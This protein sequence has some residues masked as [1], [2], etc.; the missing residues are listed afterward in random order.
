MADFRKLFLVLAVIA[1][2]AMS[3]SAQSNFSC[4]VSPATPATLRSGGLT[5]ELGDAKYTCSG[6]PT[7]GT[8]NG[9]F[10]A[11]IPGATVTNRLVSGTN[12][13]VGF[14]LVGVALSVETRDPT[15]AR[16]WVI[17]RWFTGL[18]QPS[19]PDSPA[20][21]NVIAFPNVTIPDR[22]YE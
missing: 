2:T 3:A 10:T 13:G 6:G 1:I 22:N 5:E 12:S 18:L 14:P 19:I 7:N 21:R 16:P 17:I 9:S 15:A 4:V 20:T 8:V 11:T